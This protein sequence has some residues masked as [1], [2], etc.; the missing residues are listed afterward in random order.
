MTPPSPAQLAAEINEL[1]NDA[2]KWDQQSAA[3][4]QIRSQAGALKFDRL[5]A[6]MFQVIVTEYNN[7]VT[8]VSAR[9][10]EGHDRTADVA[11]ALRTVADQVSKL[12][13]NAAQSYQQLP[14]TV[15]HP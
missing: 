4:S 15:P 1:H 10:A 13:Q 3:L 9:T 8:Q 5:E 2:S 12:D 6:G 14:A 11:A 7:V